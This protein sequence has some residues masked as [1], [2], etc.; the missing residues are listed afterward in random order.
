[1]ANYKDIHGTHVETVESDP[2]NP[3]NGQI[4]YNSTTQT[5]KGFTQNPAGSWATGNAM[6][7]GRYS[8]GATG[9]STSAIAFGGRVSP[10][11]AIIDNAET[12]NGSSWTE[13]ADISTDRLA[14]RA[15]G[16]SSNAIMAGGEEPASPYA[17]YAQTESWNGSAW[18]EVGDL[19]AAGHVAGGAGDQ[20]SGMIFGGSR[21]GRIALTE[22]WNGTSWTEVADL[23]VAAN[24]LGGAGTTTAALSIGGVIP[25]DA[26][27]GNVEDYTSPL[28]ATVTFEVS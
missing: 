8:V 13:V 26:S 16:G 18:T 10:P 28:D 11:N 22:D 9:T 3:V 12:Y 20:S 15:L 1:M 27:T 23:N 25:P 7:T 5:L 24:H 19:N 14:G 6:N 4:W 17:I 2:S 21:P